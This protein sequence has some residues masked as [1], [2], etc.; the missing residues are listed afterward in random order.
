MCVVLVTVVHVLITVSKYLRHNPLPGKYKYNIA[1]QI[2]L[3]I[4]ILTR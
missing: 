2:G 3:T 1:I 4:N